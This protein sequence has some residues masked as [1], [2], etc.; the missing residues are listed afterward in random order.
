MSTTGTTPPLIL[1]SGSG[2]SSSL[3]DTKPLPSDL[4]QRAK[5][6]GQQMRYFGLVA[7]K[8]SFSELF[9]S[10]SR[11]GFTLLSED[12]LER[13]ARFR[14]AL[15]EPDFIFTVSFKNPEK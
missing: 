5:I 13:E 2:S 10:A 11:A 14:W 7:R 1:L 4:S 9:H 6:A 15:G 8:C 12:S 3:A